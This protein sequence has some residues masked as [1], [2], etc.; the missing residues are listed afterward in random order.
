MNLDLSARMFRAF[1]FR[2]VQSASS[3]YAPLIFRGGLG[4]VSW[5]NGQWQGLPPP[6]EGLA[7]KV[8]QYLQSHH[9]ESKSPMNGQLLPGAGTLV[10]GDTD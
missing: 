9:G 10:R 8:F 7:A 6:R 2:A 5:I 1:D 4:A 3:P